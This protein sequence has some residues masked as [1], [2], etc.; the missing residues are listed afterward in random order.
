[1]VWGRGAL[2]MKQALF[3]MMEAAEALLASGHEPRRTILFAFTHDEE[4]DSTGAA[5]IAR[6]LSERGVRVHMTLDEGL[7]VTEGIVP[8]V[9]AP[10]A[11][12]GVAQKGYLT[13]ELSARGTGG[14]SSMPPATTAVSR[15]AAAVTALALDPPASR[16]Q[17]PVSE[18]F[19]ALGPELP[20]G[21]RFAMANGWLL[22]PVIL[23]ILSESPAS[24][25][26]IRTTIAPTML[27]GGIAENVL[28]QVATATINYRLLPGD[29]AEQVVADARRRI[30]DP[31]IEIRV[32][33]EAAEASGIS[34]LWSPAARPLVD[35]ARAVFPDAV[36]APGLGV[37]ISDTRRYAGIAER[38]FFFLPTRVSGPD[39]DRIHGI[40][41]RISLKHYG[42]MIRFYASFMANLSNGAKAPAN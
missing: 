12:I 15:L 11:L 22:E 30:G 18:M 10:V 37:A 13:I 20:L 17:A 5:A 2:D 36:V 38:S 35:A 9:T 29:T 21:Q 27:S 41:E 3:A 19:A 8:G 34:D 4:L 6:T 1:M 40:D 25:A 26:L 16:L 31:G 28:P 33:G 39:L 14:H 42:E 7:M 23:S 24:G 32:V